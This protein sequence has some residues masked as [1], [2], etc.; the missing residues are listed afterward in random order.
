MKVSDIHKKRIA[1][2]RNR[3][4]AACIANFLIPLRIFLRGK[5]GRHFS[6]KKIL[7]LRTDGIGDF[8]TT[9][10]AFKVLREYFTHSKITCACAKWNTEIAEMSKLFDEVKPLTLPW[11]SRAGRSSYHRNLSVLRNKELF[12][13]I[14][15]LR[16]ERFDMSVDFRGDFRNNVIMYLIGAPIRVGFSFTG[17]GYFL[18]DIVSEV[19][20]RNQ[21]EEC[22]LIVKYLTGKECRRNERVMLNCGLDEEII[23]KY[24]EI[25]KLEDFVLVHPIASQSVRQWPLERIAKVVDFIQ[26]ELDIPVLLIAQPKEHKI[27]EKI[28]SSTS[29]NPLIFYT[30]NLKQVFSAIKQSKLV[31]CH[32]SGIMHIASFLGKR[33]I[34]IVGPTHIDYFGPLN[35]D[36]VSF[37]KNYDGLS[38]APCGLERCSFQGK[39]NDETPPCINNVTEDVV[40]RAIHESLTP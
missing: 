28:R 9:L 23:K 39:A 19:P 34:A 37:I 29:T 14:K 40:M 4:I 3:L 27:L 6:L 22:S 25:N 33:T 31:I 17:L 32:E 5:S 20:G 13:T 16:S 21:F 35:I 30:K 7:L 10:P 2:K 38:C 26:K 24:I 1:D 15:E 12:C 8:I 18:T 36:V 11:A